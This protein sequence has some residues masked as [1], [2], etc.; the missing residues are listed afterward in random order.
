MGNENKGKAQTIEE[1]S[2]KLFFLN[3]Q[4]TWKLCHLQNKL[5]GLEIELNLDAEHN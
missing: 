3:T 5:I 2:I 1:N 4:M